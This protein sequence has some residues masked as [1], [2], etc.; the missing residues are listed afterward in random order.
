[1][2]SVGGL[3]VSPGSARSLLLTV[4]G[5]LVLPAGRPVWTSSLLHVLTGVGVEEQ[6]ARQAIA[7]GAAAGWIVGERHGREVRWEITP[8]GRQL[9]S[10]GARRVYSLSAAPEWDGRWLILLITIPQS[11]RTV[12]KKLYGALSWAG[13]GNPTPGVW[14]TP[15]PER[16][17]EARRVVAD[18]GLRESTLSFTGSSTDVGLSDAEIVQRAW[19][20]DGLVAMYDELLRTYDGAR[21]E[22]GD[23]VLLTHVELV[24]QWQRFPFVDPQ[25]PE[26]LLPDWIGRRAAAMF[27]QLRTEW[28]DDAHAR[29]KEV[30]EETSPG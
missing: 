6:T 7:R 21:P 4:L 11:L 19:D 23:P 25:L 22:P 13:F 3:V 29:W 16:A 14:L 28:Y 17:A 24:S 27:Q 9:I 2:P 18:L 8:A 20:L 10:D 1:M 26:A 12:R 5:E 15:H 30:V